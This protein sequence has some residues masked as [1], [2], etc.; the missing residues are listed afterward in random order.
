MCGMHNPEGCHLSLH[1]CSMSTHSTCRPALD[2]CFKSERLLHSENNA[3]R[4]IRTPS[5][6]QAVLRSCFVS[7]DVLDA[8][9][10]C[11]ALVAGAAPR[12]DQIMPC[13]RRSMQHLR[14]S[15]G[16]QSPLG[17]WSQAT[18][19]LVSMPCWSSTMAGGPLQ[20]CRGV[21]GQEQT[22]HCTR[23]LLPLTSGP[24][25]AAW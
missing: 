25:Q 18:V 12:A 15:T 6:T 3:A 23:P 11:R 7:A 13:C 5:P 21:Q 24:C 20:S 1:N 19:A 22:V 4:R 10:S 16:C 8:S 9:Q 14:S 17:P 2:C